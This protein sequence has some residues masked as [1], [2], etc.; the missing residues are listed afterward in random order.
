MK[1]KIVTKVQA[2]ILQTFSLQTH[3]N[4]ALIILRATIQ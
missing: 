1:L 4:F 2:K 3:N